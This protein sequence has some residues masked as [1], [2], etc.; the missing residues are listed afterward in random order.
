MHSYAFILFIIIIIIIHF[1]AS[2]LD[3]SGITC[4]SQITNLCVSLTFYLVAQVKLKFAL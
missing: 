2:T 1:Y 3:V 4:D